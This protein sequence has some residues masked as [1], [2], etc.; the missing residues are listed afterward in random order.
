M[1]PPPYVG[2]YVGEGFSYS[3]PRTSIPYLSISR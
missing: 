2:P 1:F 3:P